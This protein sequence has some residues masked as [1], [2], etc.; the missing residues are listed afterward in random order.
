VAERVVVSASEQYYSRENGELIENIY[1]KSVSAVRVNG[2]LSE[3]FEVAVGVR[4]RSIQ[5]GS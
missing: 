5:H 2:E 4:Q 3:W 1:N